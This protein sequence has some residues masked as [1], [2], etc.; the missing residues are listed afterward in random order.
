MGLGRAWAR[1]E[2]LTLV[3]R[4]YPYRN[5]SED[6][7]DAC[8]RYLCGRGPDGSPWLPPRLDEVRGQYT[9]T[10][11]KTAKLLSRNLGT[12]VTEEACLVRVEG[13]D[14][15]VVGELDASY[16]NVLQPGDRFLLDG[17]CLM[18]LRTDAR[19]AIVREAPGG[20][21]VPHWGNSGVRISEELARRLYFVRAEAAERLR[22]GPAALEGYLQ[23]ELGL[24]SRAS[25]ELADFLHAQEAVSEIPDCQ[26]TLI[27][28]VDRGFGFEYAVHSPLHSAGNEALAQV[29]QQRLRSEFGGKV[30]SIAVT[31]GV[32]L[33][34]EVDEPLGEEAWRRLLAIAG[35]S[36]QIEAIV[37]NGE[38]TRSRF[39]G[40]AQ[41]GL[42]VLRQPLGGPRKVGGR[43]WI[44]RR[45]FDQI[46]GVRRQRRA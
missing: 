38:L 25:R 17:R 40:I 27:E 7:F 36:G 13:D 19:E 32:V 39:A 6:D 37:R 46:G 11:R 23:R 18:L 10:S 44:E 9:V 24:G 41:T 31:L 12:I 33:F 30:M 35:F 45:L 22:D 1:D 16:A 4:G 29:L 21:L 42:M 8:L 3:R 28:V 2:A 14:G 34:H 5:L 26:S 20:P 15:F 43:D